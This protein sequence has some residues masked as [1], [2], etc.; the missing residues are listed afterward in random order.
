[1]ARPM[2]AVGLWN[3][4]AIRVPALSSAAARERVQVIQRQLEEAAMPQQPDQGQESAAAVVRDTSSIGRIDVEA[5]A[6]GASAVHN[7][8]R[9]AMPADHAPNGTAA[10]QE[11]D[12]V[13]ITRRSFPG[14][15][16]SGIPVGTPSATPYPPATPRGPSRHSAR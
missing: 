1:M 6:E 2:R 10:H 15:G 16:R 9:A 3:P 12:V 13:K 5:S 14:N 8:A 4:K 11:P 7:A